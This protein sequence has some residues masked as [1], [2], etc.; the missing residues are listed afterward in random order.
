MRHG[1]RTLGLAA[2]TTSTQPLLL[3][4]PSQQ[5]S[6]N[7]KQRKEIYL[8]RLPGPGSD[9]CGFGVL[10]IVSLNP[11]GGK[12]GSS[13]THFLLPSLQ[14]HGI[15]GLNVAVHTLKAWT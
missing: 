1:V 7:A 2:L 9:H 6:D 13:R 3:N 11:R 14:T 8:K 12:A 4:R 10:P 5:T 15:P